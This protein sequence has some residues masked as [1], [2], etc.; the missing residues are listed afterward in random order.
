MHIKNNC[1]LLLCAESLTCV[2]VWWEFGSVKRSCLEGLSKRRT[3]KQ[4]E[5]SL[6]SCSL[7]VMPSPSV[8]VFIYLLQLQTKPLMKLRWSI[9]RDNLMT[10][11][12]SSYMW[13]CTFPWL[14]VS[15]YHTQVIMSSSFKSCSFCVTFDY[16]KERLDKCVVD[17]EM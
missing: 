17:N 15:V 5:D 13:R 11:E 10:H 2:V 9:F 16:S 1:S 7:S 8:A 3:A 14:S 6:S 12:N 4:R